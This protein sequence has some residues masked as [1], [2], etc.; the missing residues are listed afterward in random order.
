MMDLAELSGSGAGG[1]VRAGAADPSPPHIQRTGRFPSVFG[2]FAMART[3]MMR[4]TLGCCRTQQLSNRHA[5]VH[6]FPAGI[7]ALPPQS[8]STPSPVAASFEAPIPYDRFLSLQQQQQGNWWAFAQQGQPAC[9]FFAGR[10]I[11]CHQFPP[12]EKRDWYQRVYTSFDV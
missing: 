3:M 11:D 9:L 4:S 1:D 2:D 8:H 12:R 6:P 5:F 7:P 10:L